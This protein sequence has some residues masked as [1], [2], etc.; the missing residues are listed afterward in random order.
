MLY[1][2]AGSEQDLDRISMQWNTW[3]RY[4]DKFKA[5]CMLK[6]N[7]KYFYQKLSFLFLGL[8][9]LV[10]KLALVYFSRFLL[11]FLCL[12]I[13]NNCLTLG[14][15]KMLSEKKVITVHFD[16]KGSG[17]R[18]GGESKMERAGTVEQHWVLHRRN[19]FLS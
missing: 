8:S 12:K 19:I 7:L 15:Q 9:T 14:D 3:V 17:M 2:D 13:D 1:V 10:L 11:A 4:F 18:K 6:M 16:S 5:K